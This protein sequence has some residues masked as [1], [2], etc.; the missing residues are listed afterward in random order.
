MKER[1]LFLISTMQ[2]LQRARYLQGFS[3]SYDFTNGS[4]DGFGNTTV[5]LDYN[6]RINDGTWKG[7]SKAFVL[8][9]I[10][11]LR[12]FHDLIPFTDRMSEHMQRILLQ[13]AVIGL[14]LL[15][16]VQ[17]TL[18]LQA[19]YDQWNCVDIRSVQAIVQ[20]IVD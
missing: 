19:E 1:V 14:E 5:V 3:R 7:T 9:W 6:A 11:K 8:N 20:A 17:I 4:H 12:L 13:N 18:E 15:C 2:G 10:D 16:N